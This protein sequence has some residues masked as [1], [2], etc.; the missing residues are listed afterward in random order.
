[1]NSPRRIPALRVVPAAAL[2]LLSA[3]L[4]VPTRARAQADPKNPHVT[5]PANPV[6]PSEVAP[7]PGMVVAGQVVI[8]QPAP[9]FE[10]DSSLG[11]PIDLNALRGDWIVL[12]FMPRMDATPSYADVQ[13]SM[14]LAGIQL[15]GICHEKA[16]SVESYAK[17]ISLG[18][19]LLADVTGEVGALYGVWDSE[20]RGF[21][22]G[23]VLLDPHGVVRYASVGRA[24]SPEQLRDVVITEREKS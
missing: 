9:A 2:L 6:A 22:P 10:L 3:T 17:R 1:M 16:R 21:M 23:F 4:A 7:H 13:H 11:R 18:W 15:V 14:G 20:V 24:L 5:V 12:L 8:G 19:M